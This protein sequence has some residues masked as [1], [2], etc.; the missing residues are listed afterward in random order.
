MCRG[1]PLA[2]LGAEAPGGNWPEMFPCLAS[3]LA[4]FCCPHERRGD[5]YF[6]GY[7]PNASSPAWSVGM[8]Y[9]GMDVGAVEMAGMLVA[10]RVYGSW[11]LSLYLFSDFAELDARSV[12]FLMILFVVCKK[13][14][15]TRWPSERPKGGPPLPRGLQKVNFLRNALS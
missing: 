11:S 10:C 9:V 4:R 12:F 13:G 6:S 5:V 7:T 1:S 15:A 8:V 3:R 2:F 14:A